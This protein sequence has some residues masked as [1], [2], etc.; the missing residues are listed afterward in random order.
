MA[1]DSTDLMGATTT[2][3]L[4]GSPKKGSGR[5]LTIDYSTSQ[6]SPRNSPKVARAAGVDHGHI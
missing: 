3:S 2:A 5:G 1:Q 4:F 6:M